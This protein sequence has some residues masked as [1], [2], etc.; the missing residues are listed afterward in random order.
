[1]VFADTL[2]CDL[3]LIV[4]TKNIL[5]LAIWERLRLAEVLDILGGGN[6][7]AKTAGIP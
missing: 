1:M 7:I 4:P 6:D 5:P 2:R 3:Q